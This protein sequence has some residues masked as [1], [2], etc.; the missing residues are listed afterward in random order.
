MNMMKR[1]VAVAMTL[2]MLCSL[3]TVATPVATASA[4]AG[5]SKYGDGKIFAWGCDMSQ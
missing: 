5:A 3:F 2:L 4:L 1:M